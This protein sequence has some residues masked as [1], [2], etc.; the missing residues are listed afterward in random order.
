MKRFLST[1]RIV[2]LVVAAVLI[3]F[4]G[5]LLTACG[6]GGTSTTTAVSTGGE[7][8]TTGAG[9]A[10]TT[11]AP[12]AAGDIPIGILVPYTGELGAYGKAWF[13][14]AEMATNDINK[15]GGI[16]NGSKIKLSTEDDGSSIE[17]GTKG[18]R[19]LI[20]ANGVIAIHGYLSDYV[21][22][23][24]PIAKAAK[25]FSS[26]PG[27]GTT[28][29]DGVGGSFEFRTCPSDA[30]SGTV[31][32]QILWDKGFKEIAL[33]HQNDEGRNSI[34]KAI[35][36]AYKKLGGKILVDV[37]FTP[38]QSTYSAELKKVADAKPPAVWLGAGQE[39][40]TTLF[41]DA[42][43]RGYKWQWM[44][45][46]DL[47]VPELFG[48]VGAQTLEGTLT[49]VP[50]ADQ[51]TEAFKAWAARYSAVYDDDPGGNYQSNSYDGVIIMALAMQAAGQ[52]TGS[53]INDKY[54]EVGNP[55][56]TKV[57][58][59]EEGMAALAKGEDINYEGISGPCD[60][61]KDG[62]VTGSYVSEIGTAGKWVVD[63]FYPAST[64][65]LAP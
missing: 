12:A 44:V 20:D 14:G 42:A 28:Q 36:A 15:A 38:G 53:G 37:P 3:V 13:R 7:T 56:G 23:A 59:F 60:F 57:Y 2:L 46:E 22:A 63:K 55:P 50:S 27:A 16:L 18:A 35:T 6:G 26:I 1:D 58:S 17:G 43:Q 65:S 40:G 49:E 64:F 32:A 54:S 10:S 33:L 9:G 51:S 41:K 21:M 39:S 52:A 19:K 30:F 11:S 24:W 25:V 47:A 62:N 4:A 29:L 48:L 5:V 45:S 31:A 34:A 61:A 8:S